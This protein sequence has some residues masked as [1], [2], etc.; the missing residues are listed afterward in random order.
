MPE[1]LSIILVPSWY[2]LSIVGF[3]KDVNDIKNSYRFLRIL[4]TECNLFIKK[5]SPYVILYSAHII[6]NCEML[7]E[8]TT[9]RLAPCRCGG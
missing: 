8:S 2:S 9:V 6:W 5:R 1:L 4:D 7:V 3:S